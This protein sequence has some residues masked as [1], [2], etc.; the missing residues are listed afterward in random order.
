M[1]I[2]LA[3]A[4]LATAAAPLAGV[5]LWYPLPIVAAVALLTH[6]SPRPRPVLPARLAVQ[7]AA[8][9]VLVGWLGSAGS[10]DGVSGMEAIVALALV[11]GAAAALANNLPVSVS[12]GTLLAAGS[13]GYAATIGLGVGAL[14]TP[15]GSVATLIAADLAG[16][17]GG[18]LTVKRLAP[19]A[20]AGVLAAAVVLAALG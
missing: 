18:A 1:A 4:G 14:A 6:P 11:V 9:L 16:P 3:I 12:A 20:L 7:L 8:L 17:A 5:P 15:Q 2:A 13:S 10:V 19:L